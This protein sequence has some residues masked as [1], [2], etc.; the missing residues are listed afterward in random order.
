M[1]NQIISYTLLLHQINHPYTSH[2]SLGDSTPLQT[3]ESA[4]PFGALHVGETIADE[5]NYAGKIEHI[6]HALGETHDGHI[7]H[8][9]SVYLKL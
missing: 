2:E 1:A 6:H 3:Y 9:I 7:T 8:V 5:G 4:S